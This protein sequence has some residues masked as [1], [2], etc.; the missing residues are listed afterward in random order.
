M[1]KK[2]AES[3]DVEIAH[4]GGFPPH[5]CAEREIET[6]EPREEPEASE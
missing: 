1:R 6:P 3:I 5:Q 4:G 2:A